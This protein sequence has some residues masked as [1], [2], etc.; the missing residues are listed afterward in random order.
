[1]LHK[2]STKHVMRFDELSVSFDESLSV[3]AS[4]EEHHGVLYGSAWLAD[5]RLDIQHLQLCGRQ[6][7]LD[8]PGLVCKLRLHILS[9]EVLS[10]WSSQR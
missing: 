6:Y 9:H 8:R 10:V 7:I 4:I 5:R 2:D 3:N 1:M